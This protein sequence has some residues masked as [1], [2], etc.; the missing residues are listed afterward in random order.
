MPVVVVKSYIPLIE[1]NMCNLN[2]T[3]CAFPHIQVND[4]NDLEGK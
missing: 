2:T 4:G 3:V 1:L